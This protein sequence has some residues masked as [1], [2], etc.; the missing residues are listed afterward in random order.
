MTTFMPD[1]SGVI[2]PMI[3]PLTEHKEIDQDGLARLVHHLLEGG[4]SGIFVLGSSGEGPWLAPSMQAQLVR[5]TKR[6]V[7]GQT[8]VLA[9]ALE[10]GTQRTLE[11]ICLHADAGADVAVI[12]T[13]Y[14]F[15]ADPA[16]QIQHVE[17]LARRSPIPVMLYNIPQMTHNPLSPDTVRR[18]A[19]I[20]NLVGLKDSAGNWEDFH[21]FVEIGQA[22]PGFAVFQGAEKLAAKSLLAGAD[23]VVPGMG[24]L[25]PRLFVQMVKYVQAGRA[26]EA[27]ARQQMLDELWTLHTYDYWLVCLKYAA[28]LLGFGSGA[29]IGHTMTMN[30][31][32]QQ[33]IRALLEKAAH[34]AVL[35]K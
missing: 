34:E 21:A 33:V 26:S 11:A 7:G 23:G 29:T 12:T 25:V 14:Y 35:G 32:A 6:L 9:G 2:P 8:P 19:G 22:H 4:V 1:L 5:E 17:T 27:L 13:P 24:N 20:D 30:P 18:L 31:E 10:A 3:T 15:G 16:V 28:S